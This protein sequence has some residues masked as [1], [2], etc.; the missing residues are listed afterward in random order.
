MASGV[1]AALDAVSTLLALL[2]ALFFLRVWR[3]SRMGLDLLLTCSFGLLALAQAASFLESG[4][5][6]DAEAVGYP[7]FAVE[8]ASVLALL[9]AYAS[10]RARTR[11]GPA[12]LVGWGF[13]GVA[14]LFALAYVL[15]P[16]PLS[17]TPIA[18][19][20]PYAHAAMA[21]AWAA[22]AGFASVAWARKRTPTRATVPL[23]Y[24]MLA[25]GYYTW[26]LVE[27]GDD[28]PLLV[29]AHLWR[30]AGIALVGLAVLIP[31][32]GGA[33]GAPA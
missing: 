21:A 3:K 24:L 14:V 22:C 8:L 31:S 15:V 27:V 13:A 16:P 29:L 10:A 17:L 7:R 6:V 26:T 19:L 32:R 4:L 30:V 11:A 1:L 23:G 20:S 25:L 9:A 2:V 33:P 18:Q 12:L 5:P 28:A